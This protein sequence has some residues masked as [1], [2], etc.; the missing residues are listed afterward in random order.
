[1]QALL[2]ESAFF[3]DIQRPLRIQGA[4]EIR[5]ALGVH[6]HGKMDREA[7]LRYR[8]VER[9]AVVPPLSEGDESPA[10]VSPSSL[11]DLN[12]FRRKSVVMADMEDIAPAT[13][14]ERC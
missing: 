8:F 1:M 6:L 12:P 11:S 13:L 4:E 14:S 9:L 2:W 5:R 3:R 10:N 7:V